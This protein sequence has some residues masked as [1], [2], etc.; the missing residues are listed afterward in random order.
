MYQHFVKC[1]QFIDLFKFSN[2]FNLESRGII[3]DTPSKEFMVNSSLQNYV[4]IDSNRNWS[5]LL[6]LE[7]YYIKRRNPSINKGLKATRELILFV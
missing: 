1:E 6:F 3:M 2:G 7:A 4:I 5:Q